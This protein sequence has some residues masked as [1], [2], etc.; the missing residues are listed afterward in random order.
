MKT[1]K[2]TPKLLLSCGC[3]SSCMLT[4]SPNMIFTTSDGKPSPWMAH[5]IC[6]WHPRLKIIKHRKALTKSTTRKA[7]A[8]LPKLKIP[9]GKQNNSHNSVHMHLLSSYIHFIY[10]LSCIIIYKYPVREQEENFRLMSVLDKVTWFI[11]CLSRIADLSRK[12]LRIWGRIHGTTP[13]KHKWELQGAYG[14]SS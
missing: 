13:D 7:L 12:L 10:C 9:G 4:L 11:A 3:Q 14:D 6:S 5:A 8:A 1:K 2:M